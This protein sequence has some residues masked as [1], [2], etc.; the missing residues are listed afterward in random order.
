MQTDL[1]LIGAV[2]AGVVTWRV[3][4]LA[5]D[6]VWK[7]SVTTDYVTRKDCENCRRESEEGQQQMC[8]DVKDVKKLLYVVAS[9]TPGVDQDEIKVLVG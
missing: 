2:V 8:K 9:K 1:N 7:R 6:F 3:L 5:V 4:G